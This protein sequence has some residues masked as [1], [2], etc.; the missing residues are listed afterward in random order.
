MYRMCTADAMNPRPALEHSLSSQVKEWLVFCMFIIEV[1]QSF[2]PK[3]DPLNIYK[4]TKLIKNNTFAPYRP[5]YIS[6][7]YYSGSGG[8]QDGP[9][10]SGLQLYYYYIV[11]KQFLPLAL[12]KGLL[13]TF[14]TQEILFVYYLFKCLFTLKFALCICAI[15]SF[16]V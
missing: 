6:K 13:L 1:P 8:G 5:P 2:M 15:E 11:V 9:S 10:S 3:I 14:K 16:Y 12:W 7:H 4:L